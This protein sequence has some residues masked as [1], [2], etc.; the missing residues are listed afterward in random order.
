MTTPVLTDH[1]GELRYHVPVPDD[2]VGDPHV[3]REVCWLMV[4][5]GLTKAVAELV[6]CARCLGVGYDLS[7]EEAEVFRLLLVEG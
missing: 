7:L 5:R 4:T 3:F 2:D 6:A 1:G